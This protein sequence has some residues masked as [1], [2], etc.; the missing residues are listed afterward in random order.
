MSFLEIS[1]WCNPRSLLV[2]NEFGTLKRL[3]CPFSVICVEAV[4]ELSEFKLY[5]V[6]SVKMT[7][8]GKI[9]YNV[10]G[11]FFFHSAFKIIEQ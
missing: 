7:E 9:V 4:G 11:D 6:D 8:Q 5:K 3:N 2:V 1:Q 10:A